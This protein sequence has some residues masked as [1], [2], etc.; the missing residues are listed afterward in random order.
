MTRKTSIQPN[1]SN[2]NSKRKSESGN[3]FLFILIGIVLFAAISFVMSRGFRSE[4]T[5]KLTDRQAELGATEVIEFAQ[6]VARGVDRVRR[7]G[8][9]EN[10]ISFQNH[11]GLSKTRDGTPYDYTNASTPTDSSCEV[12]HENGGSV[13]PK[14]IGEKYVAPAA[15][16]PANIM[17]PDSWIVQSVRILGVGSDTGVAGSELAIKIGRLKKDVCMAI[18]D[19]LG[20]TNPSNA[21]P[22]DVQGCD[23]A[24]FQGTFADCTEPSGNDVTALQGKQGFC[25]K[26]Y[27]SSDEIYYWYTHVLIE[28]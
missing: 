9:S 14:L 1:K 28:R 4:G 12:F 25:S 5:S 19:R 24:I 10:E 11:R 7:K 16:V 15:S 21:P 18:N 22:F 23:S 26:V 27:N 20:I 8:C 2:R 3:V 17:A 6:R 13:T